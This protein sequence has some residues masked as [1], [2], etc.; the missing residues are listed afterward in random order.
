MVASV[1]FLLLLSLG[2]AYVTQDVRL[3]LFLVPPSLTYFI[4]DAFKDA[5]HQKDLE[6]KL[7]AKYESRGAAAGAGDGT[8][9]EGKAKQPATRKTPS[10]RSKAA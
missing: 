6:K 1:A 4:L 3:L 7:V 2:G 10:R 5:R 9:A 8:S